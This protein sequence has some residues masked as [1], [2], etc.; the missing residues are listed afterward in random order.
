M[1]QTFLTENQFC[2]PPFLRKKTLQ[3]RAFKTED[4]CMFKLEAWATSVVY[5]SIQ[6]KLM[7][8]SPSWLNSWAST[9]RNGIKKYSVDSLQNKLLLGIIYF[10]L[11]LFLIS[12]RD[13]WLNHALNTELLSV[14]CC[15]F[16]KTSPIPVNFFFT[17]PFHNFHLGHT[18]LCMPHL[19]KDET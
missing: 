13:C 15:M 16:W 11:L 18:I 4:K 5:A 9:C 3:I 14:I 17:R 7:L 1:I 10:F 19:H 8:K 2:K 6:G 12:W